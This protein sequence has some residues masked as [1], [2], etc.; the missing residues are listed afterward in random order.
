MV[1]WKVSSSGAM[2]ERDCVGVVAVKC[3]WE[4]VGPRLIFVTGL[5][6]F[7]TIVATL[8]CPDLLG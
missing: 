7:V 4:A 3:G 5:V 8:V 2:R 1:A 6:K